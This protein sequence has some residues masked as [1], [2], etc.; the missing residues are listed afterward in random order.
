MKL[1]QTFVCLVLF[2]SSAAAAPP[3]LE[4]IEPAV[5]QLGTEFS[6]VATGAGFKQFRDLMFYDNGLQLLEHE[7]IS[8]NE[9]KLKIRALPDCALGSHFFRILTTDGCSELRS[10]TL[11]PYPIIAETRTNP[12][13]IQVIS[14]DD[15][16]P[17]V[18]L[19]G[20]LEQGD[21]DRYKATFKKLERVTVEVAAVRLGYYLFDTILSVYDPNGSLVATVD[22]TTLY[23]Q[24][25]FVTF[26]A[27]HDGEYTIEVRE[28]TYE[29][30]SRS[31]YA[32]HIG[33]FPRP[34]FVFPA[35]GPIG[36]KFEV[37]IEGDYAG[38]AKAAVSPEANWS[39][40]GLFV[41]EGDLTAPTATPF[42]AVPFG[43]QMEQEPNDTPE[44]PS[45]SPGAAEA[46]EL[47]IAFNG[48]LERPGDMDCFPFR[49]T[50]G[51]LYSF[52]VYADRVGSAA[53]TVITI[54]SKEGRVLVRNDDGNTHDSRLEF[55][56]PAT[57]TYFLHVTDKL[58]NGDWRFMYRV[59]ASERLPKIAAFLPR[60]I[61]RSQEGQTIGVPQGNRALIKVGVQRTLFSGPVAVEL[62][63]LPSGLQSSP[64][65][66]ESDLY[67]VPVVLTAAPTSE[68]GGKLIPAKV[69]PQGSDMTVVDGGF[70]QI[71][72][73]IDGPADTVFNQANLDRL[74]V[75]VI[76]RVPFSVDIVPPSTSLPLD[77]S[78]DLIVR[79]TRDPS[80][81]GPIQVSI[82]V[83][84]P[85]SYAEAKIEIP[86]DQTEARYTINSLDVT[87][88]RDWLLC[89]EAQATAKG[90]AAPR[91]GRSPRSSDRDDS[92]S[93]TSNEPAAQPVQDPSVMS[94]SELAGVRVCSE[95]A[96]LKITPSP[97]SG[98][99][100]QTAGEQGTTI[101]IICQIDWIGE[102]PRPEQLSAT[103]QELPNRVKAEPVIW[104]GEKE[105]QIPL[106]LE[107]DS[108]VGKFDSVYLRLTGSIDGQQVSYNVARG[109]KL[110]ITPP[111]KLMRD[112][113]GEALNPLE[114]LRRSQNK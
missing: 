50:E 88:V 32:L 1:L 27:E 28:T 34:T 62:L 18:T 17:N 6:V 105:I 68:I 33:N 92:G 106:K 10:L 20:V 40:K 67:W 41:M 9:V 24:D 25:P 37:A 3:S 69:T 84:P 99:M 109:T 85:D 112:E 71:V 36:E 77:G 21:R 81:D 89:C 63:D 4:L 91:G 65:Q 64:I 51:K 74:A 111:G 108:P 98:K 43:N 31:R 35:G 60:P 42:R 61:R 93:E 14:R 82:P 44:L 45:G 22:D 52:E 107:T 2:S 5:G 94:G 97:V 47:P 54:L 70:N 66:L 58:A 87:P 75:S 19:L 72:D 95:I 110:V 76:R 48:V 73:L 39:Q 103:L 90:R 113:K 46:A 86:A 13:E 16:R 101:N 80:F 23:K 56:A 59:E 57:D 78:L 83:L 38:A 100:T 12:E 53:D 15:K 96:K 30:D 29:G 11:T 8:E 49:T 102:G 79:V 104:K 7:V 26:V 114:A 55:R